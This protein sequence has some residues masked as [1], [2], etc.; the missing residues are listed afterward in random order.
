MILAEQVAVVQYRI[1]TI[2]Q[3]DTCRSATSIVFGKRGEKLLE[4]GVGQR[5]GKCPLH[6][7]RPD[8]VP[9]LG[10][11]RVPSLPAKL[12][13]ERMSFGRLDHVRYPSH[14]SG[15]VSTSMIG[16]E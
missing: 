1:S 6:D 8:L 15:A 5:D 7:A 11:G 14:S 2:W 10:R 4:L 3:N 12:T 13:V 9:L 16:G